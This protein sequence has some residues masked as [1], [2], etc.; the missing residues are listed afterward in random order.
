MKFNLPAFF[1]ALIFFAAVFFLL[2]YSVMELRGLELMFD[3][4]GNR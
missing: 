1:G 2:D 3:E 4:T